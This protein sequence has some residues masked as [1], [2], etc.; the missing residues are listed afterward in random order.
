MLRSVTNLAATLSGNGTIGA[1]FEVAK[2]A[3]TQL[4]L[5]G[6]VT[7]NGNLILTSGTLRLSSNPNQTMTVTGNAAMQGGVLDG[8]DG[9][10]G[11][12]DPGFGER[13]AADLAPHA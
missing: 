1:D 2:T 3:A 5:N 7:V 12:V 9:R 10:D 8:L 13:L 6:N 4:M 11:V